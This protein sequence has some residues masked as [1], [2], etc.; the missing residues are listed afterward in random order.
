MFANC[1]HVFTGV[2]SH[3]EKTLRPLKCSSGH[4]FDNPAEK[5]S[6]NVQKNFAQSPRKLI[7]IFFFLQKK[8]IFPQKVLLEASIYKKNAFILLKSILIKICGR[9]LCL[10]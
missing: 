1:I 4:A 3:L 8:Y 2:C 10:C 6:P 9:K 7:N 5:F